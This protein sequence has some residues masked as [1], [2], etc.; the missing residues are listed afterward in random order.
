MGRKEEAERKERE[1]AE[2]ARLEAERKA[3][4]EAD[5]KSLDDWVCQR[6]H[7]MVCFSVEKG[8]PCDMCDKESANGDQFWGCKLEDDFGSRVCS[9][10]I[11]ADCKNSRL[12]R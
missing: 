3:K 5:L 6:G 4:E 11:C 8:F 9:W 1:K 10:D 7:A 2:K 12:R